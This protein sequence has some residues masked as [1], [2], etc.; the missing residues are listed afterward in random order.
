MI[1]LVAKMSYVGGSYCQNSEVGSKV[2]RYFF[3]TAIDNDDTF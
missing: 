1:I 3:S 2:P